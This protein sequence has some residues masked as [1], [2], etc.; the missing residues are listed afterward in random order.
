MVP[1][2]SFRTRVDSEQTVQL[3]IQ[4][5]FLFGFPYRG[6]LHTLTVIDKSPG[7]SPA[8]RRIA[9]LNQNNTLSW[10]IHDYIH[11]GY[12]IAIDRDV[13]TT[14]WALDMAAHKKSPSKTYNG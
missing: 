4:A 12:G 1:R 6:L 8:K 7:Q 3:H 2:V 14:M 10:K 13:F 11:C 9:A 5:G